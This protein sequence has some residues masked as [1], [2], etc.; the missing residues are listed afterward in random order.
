MVVT[1][2][3][4]LSESKIEFINNT[5]SFY[6][7]VLFLLLCSICFVMLI[8]L[9]GLDSNPQEEFLSLLGGARI[10]PPIHQFLVSSLGEVV[11]STFM[12]NL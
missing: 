3:L 6:S 7:A 2:P 8:F 12:L 4:T 5:F 9:I 11:L 1:D 10:S